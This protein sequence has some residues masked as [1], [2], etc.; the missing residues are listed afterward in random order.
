ML[1]Q[2]VDH[3][4]PGHVNQANKTGILTYSFELLATCIMGNIWAVSLLPRLCHP[5]GKSGI[6]RFAR[7]G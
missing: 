6:R 5:V 1:S 7:P 4:K 2:H 3:A